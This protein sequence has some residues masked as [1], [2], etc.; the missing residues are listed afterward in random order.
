[1]HPVNEH[2]LQVIFLHI[3]H[4]FALSPFFVFPQL[5]HIGILSIIIIVFSFSYSYGFSEFSLFFVVYLS[6]LFLS[7]ILGGQPA[8]NRYVFKLA[9]N[10]EY[11]N[12]SRLRGTFLSSYKKA[13]AG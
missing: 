7:V 10:G 8:L 6:P 4:F 1:V 9:H 12:S 2:L 5:G 3:E 13:E 11:K